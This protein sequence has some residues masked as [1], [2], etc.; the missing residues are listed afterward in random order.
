MYELI[1]GNLK[2][3]NER[4]WFATCLRLGKIYLDSKN[5]AQLETILVEM[6]DACKRPGSVDNTFNSFDMSKGNLLLEVFALEIQMC[7]ETKEQRRMKD[8]FILTKKF[9][10]V[11]EDPR[12]VGIIRECGAKMY[13]SE[14]RWEMAN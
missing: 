11:I 5:F 12:V 13:M 14:K 8:V 4:L 3:S 1:L 7:I 2:Q 6:K 10:S 9:S